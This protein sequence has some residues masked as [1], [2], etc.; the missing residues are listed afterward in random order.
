MTKKQI[1]K[2][3]NKQLLSERI[4][5]IHDIKARIDRQ[6]KEHQKNWTE[7]MNEYISI[8]KDV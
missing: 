3:V 7:V 6:P 8:N 2:I 4:V 1:R 5:A